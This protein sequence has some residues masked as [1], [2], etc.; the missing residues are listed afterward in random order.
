VAI[1]VEGDGESF[2]AADDGSSWLSSLIALRADIASGDD[3][4]LN[5][6]WLLEVQCGGIDDTAVEPA[7]PEGLARE[8]D[9]VLDRDL[10]AETARALARAVGRHVTDQVIRHRIRDELRALADEHRLDAPDMP[11][12]RALVRRDEIVKVVMSDPALRE[13]IAGRPMAR[14]EADNALPAAPNAPA[15]ATEATAADV[16]PDEVLL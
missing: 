13:E 2:D 4:A 16:E 3:R 12:A 1:S 9:D 10:L 7:R 15:Q 14:V 8:L 11:E 6:G 5:L